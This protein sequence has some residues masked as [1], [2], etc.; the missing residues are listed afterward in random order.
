VFLIT[1]GMSLDLEEIA[2]QWGA[3]LTAVSGVVI[4]KAL[5]TSGLLW[6][7]GARAGVATETGLLMASPSETTLIVLATAAQAKLILPDT[8][9]FWQIVTAIGLTI[10]PLLARVGHDIARRVEMR[11]TPDSADTVTD[12]G[13]RAVIVG[14]GRV[15]RLVAQ[16]LAAHKRPY[17]AIDADIDTIAHARRRKYNIMFGDIT[18][19]GML[20]R[21]ELDK[22]SALILTMDEPVQTIRTVRRVRELY[23]DLTIVA[24]ARDPNHAAELYRAGVTDA[25]PETL[26]SSLQLSEAVLVDLGVAMGPVIASIH[27]KR[28]ELRAKIM[29]MADTKKEPPLRGVR[30]RDRLTIHRGDTR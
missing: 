3:L 11:A 1:V 30:L 4:A 16:M 6:F 12:A 25:V 8:A 18:R 13:G 23:P 21:L 29:E 26:E 24:R 19:P 17:I 22:A 28:A 14:F 5:V 7:S 10:T 9:A 2:N 27:E 15:G 20:E